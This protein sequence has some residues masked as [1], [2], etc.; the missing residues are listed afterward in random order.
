M[1]RRVL[2]GGAIFL[3]L[4][5]RGI[6]LWLVV[7][8]ACCMWLV[9]LFVRPMLGQPNVSLGKVIGWADL[10]LIAAIAQ[11]L[12]RPFERSVPFTPWTEVSKVNHRVRLG[13]PW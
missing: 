9:M 12:L 7:P 3:L 1:P 6:L 5:V 10:N 8:I 2:E 4:C 11:P 13:D